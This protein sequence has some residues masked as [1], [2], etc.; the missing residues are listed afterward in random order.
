MESSGLTVKRIG[1]VDENLILPLGK[2]CECLGHVIP[3]HSKKHHFASGR[4]FFGDSH[5]S[6][7]K[8][9]DDLSQALGTSVI[10]KLYL[11]ADLQGPFCK[12]LCEISRSNGS[13][14]HKHCFLLKLLL[15]S[16]D[17]LL[18]CPDPAQPEAHQGSR[19]ELINLTFGHKTNARHR[20]FI[21][22]DSD[23]CI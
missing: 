21:Y 2:T 5:C 6:W 4:L 3:G 17:P 1:P 13:N 14:F 11:V 19:T 15:A 23:R 9:I 16:K 12:R 22:Q 10:A 20:S 18:C 8:L 7:T